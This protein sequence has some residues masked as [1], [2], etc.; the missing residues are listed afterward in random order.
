VRQLVIVPRL[1]HV[2]IEKEEGG[3]EVLLGGGG[4]EEEGG[5]RA[6]DGPIVASGVETVL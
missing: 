2:S 5:V 4:G 3:R 6:R 1:L